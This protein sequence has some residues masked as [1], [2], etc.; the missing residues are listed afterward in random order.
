MCGTLMVSPRLVEEFRVWL[1]EDNPSLSE[2]TLSTYVARL[3]E[4]IGRPLTGDVLRGFA[5]KS[6][7]HFMTASR[8]LTFLR[9]RYRLKELA[10]ELREALGKRPRSGVDTW[11]PPD[12]LVLDAGRALRCDR[13]LY[14]VWLLLVSTGARLVEV[15]YALTEADWS[16]L[17]CLDTHCRLHIDMERGSKREWVLY[18]PRTVA[19]HI[20]SIAGREYVASYSSL[21]KALIRTGVAAKYYRNWVANKMLILGIPE[22]VVDFVQGRTPTTTLRRHYLQ[23]LQQADTFYPRYAEYLNTLLRELH[24]QGQGP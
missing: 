17:V 6:K 7:W 11:V 10:E 19:K 20:A 4:L 9:K 18:M 14:A 1:L 2:K 16:R 24:G 15:R 5:S 12:G 8:L 21:E 22:A 23:L 3:R 13:V